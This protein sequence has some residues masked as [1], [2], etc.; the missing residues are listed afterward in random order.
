MPHALVRDDALIAGIAFPAH[1]T[2]QSPQ[3][4]R[5]FLT[6]QCRM[7]LPSFAP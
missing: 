1:A 6:T 5:Q 2:R 3:S 7:P 4:L